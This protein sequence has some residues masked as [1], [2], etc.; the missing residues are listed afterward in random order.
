MNTRVAMA[1][2]LAAMVLPWGAAPA[3]AQ[4]ESAR[5]SAAWKP[6]PVHQHL[7]GLAGEYTTTTTFRIKPGDAARETKGTARLTSILGGRFLS[8]ETGGALFGQPTAS[9][10]L[11]GYNDAAKQFEATWVYTG[12]TAMMSLRGTSKDDGKTIE[13]S[14][15]FAE[16]DGKEKT[17]YVVQ[18]FLDPDHFTAELYAKNPDGSKGPT[19]ETRYARKK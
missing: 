17:L 3:V 18:H 8:E 10:H 6:G 4:Q 19:L 2:V 5:Q 12:S 16:A 13:W 14:G 15:S 7:A 9:L 1:G 11:W